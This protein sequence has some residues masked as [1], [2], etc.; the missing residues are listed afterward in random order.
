[1]SYQV[2]LDFGNYRHYVYAQQVTRENYGYF[3]G[4]KT[5]IGLRSPDGGKAPVVVPRGSWVVCEPRRNM[6][7]VMSDREF[8]DRYT[9]YE[10]LPAHLKED[11]D[12]KVPSYE[13]WARERRV[14]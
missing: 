7:V 1:M 2:A 5:T 3:P 12:A 13:A 9:L 4:R 8:R 11:V 10:L 14:A 6:E